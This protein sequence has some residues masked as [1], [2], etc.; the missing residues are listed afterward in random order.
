MPVEPYKDKVRLDTVYRYNANY[1][2][3]ANNIML[4]H[5]KY[6]LE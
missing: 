5:L 3:H 6:K 2:N 1:N 4:K